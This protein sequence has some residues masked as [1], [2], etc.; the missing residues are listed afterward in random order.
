MPTTAIRFNANAVIGAMFSDLGIFQP[1]DVVPAPDANGALV[2]LNTLISGLQLSPRAMPFIEREV[3]DVV[4]GQSTYT[5][6]PGG[7]FDTI[8]PMALTGTSLLQPSTGATVGRNEI[9]R[10][11]I[12]NDA[13]EAINLKDLQSAMWTNVFFNPTYAD[14]LASVRLWPVPNTTSNAFVMYR[15]DAVQGFTNLTTQDDYQVG[16]FELLEYNLGKRVAPSYGGTG[17]TSEL[18]A[19]RIEATSQFK[20]QNY[21]LSDL[22]VDPAMT[23]N[24]RTRGGY[25][26]QVGNG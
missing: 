1:G 9:A 13:Y 2:R 19:L 12:T 21:R 11:L 4:A 24:I 23:R 8:R 5:I 22:A 16:L 15:G 10:A 17:W 6:G 7:D 3:F 26:I 25:I 14:G 18:E 20:R